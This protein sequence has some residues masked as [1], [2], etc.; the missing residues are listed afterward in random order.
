MDAHPVSYPPIHPKEKPGD[1]N[2]LVSMGLQK[3]KTDEAFEEYSKMYTRSMEDPEGFWGDQA[4]K[5][6]E[7]IVPYKVSHLLCLICDQTAAGSQQL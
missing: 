7:F 2:I 6:L 1:G 5:F 3:A 4:S